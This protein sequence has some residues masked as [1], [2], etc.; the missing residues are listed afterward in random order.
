MRASVLGAIGRRAPRSW[1]DAAVTPAVR[2]LEAAG[3][4]VARHPEEI[5]SLLK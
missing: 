2:A 4:K 5:P 3:V 1:L